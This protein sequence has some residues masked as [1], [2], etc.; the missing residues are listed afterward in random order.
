MFTT[1][2]W[3]KRCTRLLP[4]LVSVV[5]VLVVLLGSPAQASV[6]PPPN[7]GTIHATGVKENFGQVPRVEFRI[8]AVDLRRWLGNGV[9]TMG[10]VVHYHGDTNY[11]PYNASGPGGAATPVLSVVYGFDRPIDAEATVYRSNRSIACRQF[12]GVY[13][14]APGPA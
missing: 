1:D 5:V 6:P 9:G 11:G 2:S 7:C 14:V 10:V 3:P 4:A 12:I 8:V 13:P